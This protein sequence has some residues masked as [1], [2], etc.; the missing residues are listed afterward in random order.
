MLLRREFLL[1]DGA[2]SR[3]LRNLPRNTQFSLNR[4][5]F[6][7]RNL[8]HECFGF[9]PGCAT[10]S[11]L[12]GGW[13]ILAGE[14]QVPFRRVDVSLGGQLSRRQTQQHCLDWI[15]SSASRPA[16]EHHLV[17]HHGI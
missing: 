3:Y 7:R 4:R 16:S 13:T 9:V 14:V 17:L 6:S 11:G 10:V 8:S 5:T 2:S 15:V 12:W 1:D